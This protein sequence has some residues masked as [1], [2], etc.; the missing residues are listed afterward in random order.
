MRISNVTNDNLV[1]QARNATEFSK[2]QAVALKMEELDSDLV[3]CS[4]DEH[5][6][7]VQVTARWA[8]K[9]AEEFKEIYKLAKQAI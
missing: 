4:E 5:E 2:A 7:W 6:L 1:I 8:P 3:V 9:Q